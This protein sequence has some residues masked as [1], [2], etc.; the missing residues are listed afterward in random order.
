MRVSGTG[1]EGKGEQAAV[2]H[3]WSM[4]LFEWRTLQR[5]SR[6]SGI[7][8]IRSKFH[9]NEEGI[10]LLTNDSRRLGQQWRKQIEISPSLLFLVIWG[11]SNQ[12]CG[13]GKWGTQPG[14]TWSCYSPNMGARAL[15]FGQKSCWDQGTAW[16]HLQSNPSASGILGLHFNLSL[17]ASI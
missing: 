17:S 6:N 13:T 12:P 8:A 4:F 15:K 5:F 1:W 2:L 7:S 9:S 16:W 10:K 14:S 3:P 11:C